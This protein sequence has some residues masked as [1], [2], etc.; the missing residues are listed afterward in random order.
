[1]VK[2]DEHDFTREFGRALMEVT[3]WG[4]QN[5]RL[6]ATGL[7]KGSA[8]RS[9]MLLLL[10]RYPPVVVE[11]KF[12]SSAGSPVD[13]CG[14]Y[15]RLQCS[16]HANNHTGQ[17]VRLGMAV[18]YPK[19]AD[20]WIGQKKYHVDYIKDWFA[21]GGNFRYK[22]VSLDLSGAESVWPSGSKSGYLEGDMYDF[23]SCLEKL[24][25][26][27]G[28]VKAV[29]ARAAEAI[30]DA[31]AI[32]HAK[33]Q[34]HKSE[35]DRISDLVGEKDHEAGMKTACL[36]WLDSMLVLNE[37]C[38]SKIVKAN[39]Q[40]CRNGSDEAVPGKIR[41]AWKGV[42][43]TNYTSVF[44]PA[45]DTF[46]VGLS[47]SNF[48]DAFTMILDA[49][50]DIERE[51]LGHTSS[52]AGEVFASVLEETTRENIAAYYTRLEAAEYLA[53]LAMP[54]SSF[55]DADFKKWRLA[56]FACGTGTL[57][58]AGYRRLK[59]FALARN[60]SPSDLH[61]H[62]MSEN[63]LCGYDI[64]P[65][66]AHLTAT[67]LVQ[68]Q[69][70]T[71]YSKTNIGVIRLGKVN[72]SAKSK[73]G[74]PLK[75]WEEVRA[76]SIEL[77]GKDTALP[78]LSL[79]VT[80]FSGTVT[81]QKGEGEQDLDALHPNA[82]DKSFDAVLMNPPYSG[83]HGGK[84]M[85]QFPWITEPERKAVQH[86][87]KLLASGTCSDFRAGLVSTFAEIASRKL[88]DN[89]R[90]GLV[91]PITIA[92]T[93]AYHKTRQMIEKNF[94]DVIIT[95]FQEGA[96]GQSS[97]VSADTAMG[98]CMITARRGSKGRDG[99]AFV[100]LDRYFGS[101]AEATEIAKAVQ[102]AVNGKKPGDYGVVKAGNDVAGRWLIGER[103]N[104]VWGAA[105]VNSLMELAG[106]IQNMI[107]GK[108]VHAGMNDVGFDVAKISDLFTAG[109][110]HDYIGHIH[111]DV[112]KKLSSFAFHDYDPAKL[113]T[114]S[115]DLTIWSPKH[116]GKK[117]TIMLEPTHYG[118][119]KG[120]VAQSHIDRIRGEKTDLFYNKTVRWTFQ[121]A[122]VARTTE[123]A[124]GGRG[125]LG[126]QYIGDDEDAVKFAFTVWSNSIFG[127]VSHWYQTG[128]QSD[129]RSPA[130]VDD[131]KNL[132]IPDFSKP[133]MI[134]RTKAAMKTTGGGRHYKNIFS[135]N[136]QK[137][138]NANTDQKRIDLGL[139]AARILGIPK[140]HR[141]KIVSDLS[142]L[143]AA[144]A[145]V[146]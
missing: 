89:G 138:N 21:N 72:V 120:S 51:R 129:G 4:H 14:K 47:S 11:C 30:N 142:K 133:A 58:R 115:P 40:N 28:R 54:D 75:K 10:P 82:E 145:S 62:L 118:T 114:R 134:K 45:Y 81:T 26:T 12:A 59:N 95:F 77:L 19:G 37:L 8:K 25:A 84:P 32:V 117:T 43:A 18:V 121:K 137:C 144:E 136:Y 131:I 99:I 48:V 15:M 104:R 98:E 57:L 38:V 123:E 61:A 24:T 90:L 17:T 9:D 130:N 23:I 116:I 53:R 132:V 128:K 31:A 85:F 110:S 97:A 76:G 5:V 35:L 52:V 22:T 88:K 112:P 67:N 27:P 34:S 69:P 79:E 96:S 139:L 74:K 93:S 102:K 71:A 127:L 44:Q 91:S 41:Q 36:I 68:M 66:A 105:G 141:K 140:E 80:D 122:L 135:E 126:L 29:S 103:G 33:L 107:N 86:R 16:S 49:V 2:M 125:Y 146:K 109:S 13:D 6:N 7:F 73:P 106:Q 92:G 70:G 20:S 1:M 42:L 83:V 101:Q 3:G 63:G 124:M 100:C 56:D 87:A 94:S 78:K 60:V 111:G 55:L 119:P 64:S 46:P 143:W 113:S 50:D 39:S 65:I 108:I